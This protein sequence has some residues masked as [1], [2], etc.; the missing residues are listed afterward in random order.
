[1][2]DLRGAKALVTGGTGFIGSHLRHR[3]SSIGCH[4]SFTGRSNPDA[5]PNFL[6][7]SLSDLSSLKDIVSQTNPDLVFHL[8]ASTSRELSRQL[9]PHMLQENA[10]SVATLCESIPQS[11]KLIVV[12]SA[13]EYGGAP[14]P[15]TEESR[16]QP[17]SPY[18]LSKL[19][20]A[21]IIR[22]ASSTFQLHAAAIRPSIVFGPGQ[23]P[24]MFIPS[25]LAALQRGEDFAMTAGEQQRDFIFIDDVVDA[26]LA[27]LHPNASGQVFNISTGVSTQ[28]VTLAKL[29]HQLIGR[30]SLSVGALSYRPNEV[31]QQQMSPQKAQQLLSW[32]AKTSLE[33]GLRRTIARP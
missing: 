5:A 31:M 21:Q 17:T 22:L 19:V 11:A 27:A 25:L 26:L 16:E 20:A 32:T 30:G 3:L 12:G 4:V 29:A 18:G 28:I 7:L 6:P 24:N 9:L 23:R 10:L 1:M 33:D 13:E 14:S 8:A 2:D 15:W